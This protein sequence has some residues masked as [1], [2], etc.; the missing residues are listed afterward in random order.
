MTGTMIAIN[1]IQHCLQI[2]YINK[3][4]TGINY[5]SNKFQNN[6]YLSRYL[7]NNSSLSNESIFINY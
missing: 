2:I 6:S 5:D 1:E 4:K 7:P 3:K